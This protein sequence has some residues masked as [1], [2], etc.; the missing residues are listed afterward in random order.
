M[1][2][3]GGLRRRAAV[4]C[5]VS[6]R[7]SSAPSPE[8]DADAD[9][10]DMAKEIGNGDS[11]GSDPVRPS[12]TWVFPEGDDFSTPSARVDD[13][14]DGRSVNPWALWNSALENDE[15][16]VPDSPRDPSVETN[17]WRDAVKSI[18]SEATSRQTG[19]SLSERSNVESSQVGSSDAIDELPSDPR[20]LWGAA[21][22]VTASVSHLQESLREEIENFNPLQQSDAYRDI[23]R[24]L[25]G[26]SGPKDSTNANPGG[27]SE[28]ADSSESAGRN[29][30]QERFSDDLGS[31]LNAAVGSGWNPDVDW[32]RYDDTNRDLQ[33][34]A[35]ASQRDDVRNEAERLRGEALAEANPANPARTSPGAE[36]NLQTYVDTDGRVLSPEDVTEALADGAIVVDEDGKEIPQ[37]AEGGWFADSAPAASLSR[38]V[39]ADGNWAAG[40]K[41]TTA[42][43]SRPQANSPVNFARGRSGRT[44]GP[45]VL[46]TEEEM[47]WLKE[48]GFRRRDPEEE[49]AFW[50]DAAREIGMASSSDTAVDAVEVP[51]DANPKVAG[52]ASTVTDRDTY[53][54]QETATTLSPDDEG[55]SVD[56][57]NAWELW[58]SSSERWAKEVESAPPRDAKAEVDMWRST[59]RSIVPDVVD[60][61]HSSV[62]RISRRGESTEPTAWDAWQWLPTDEASMWASAAR[63]ICGASSSESE[64][65]QETSRGQGKDATASNIDMWKQAAR[66]FQPP[67]SSPESSGGD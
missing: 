63:E 6:P 21:S 39:A 32:K 34:K 47:K 61:E 8:G 23:A 1:S 53:T 45:D 56:S 48:R 58:S 52:D 4:R 41:P 27:V 16:E 18:V 10:L 37:L 2:P 26:P 22:R 7:S 5:A 38:S 9:W 42:P 67:P 28:A 35:E 51:S 24:D 25:V 54:E 60:G 64:T 19:D 59:A 33:R 65:N 15:T 3:V 40:G 43:T 17:F 49:K 66:E 57:R 11:T 13:D 20:Q 29:V 55:Q 50:R 62:A 14:A 46:D 31:E 12:P 36:A 44:Y 30:A